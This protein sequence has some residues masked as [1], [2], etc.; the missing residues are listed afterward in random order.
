MT[1]VDRSAALDGEVA[2]SALP[3][4]PQFFP[5]SGAGVGDEPALDRIGD[6]ALEAAQRLH[7]GLG[8]VELASVVGTAF[9]VVA[10]L[11]GHAR[12]PPDRPRA[13]PSGA[14]RGPARRRATPS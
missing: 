6:P 3:D 13:S 2:P 14:T 1:G 11:R 7:R 4:P 10:D 9:G 8:L 5:C 12:R